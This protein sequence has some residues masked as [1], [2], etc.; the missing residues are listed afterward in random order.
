MALQWGLAAEVATSS[1]EAEPTQH[2]DG[3]PP[4]QC[5]AHRALQSGSSWQAVAWAPR[6]VLC[7]VRVVTRQREA[8]RDKGGAALGYRRWGAGHMARVRV[9]YDAVMMCCIKVFSPV[10]VTSLVT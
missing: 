4:V 8:P 7:G 5:S 6:I 2:L 3:V 1:P 9:V 10:P